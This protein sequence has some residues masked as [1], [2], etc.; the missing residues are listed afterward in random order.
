[1][2]TL[3]LESDKLAFDRNGTIFEIVLS[4]RVVRIGG[5]GNRSGSEQH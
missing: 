1:M 5:S 4:E 3:I 2:R